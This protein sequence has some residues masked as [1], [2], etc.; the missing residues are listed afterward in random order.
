MRTIANL[1][2]HAAPL[3]LDG[4]MGQEL[5]ARGVKCTEGLWS[6]RAL[7]DDPELVYEVHRDFVAAGADIL[8]TNTYAATRRRLDAIDD[9]AF[10]RVNRTAC[11]LARRAA[12]EADRPVLVAGSLPPIHGSYRPDEVR[13]YDELEPLYREH[14]ALLAEHVDVLLCETMSTADEARA[15]AAGAARTGLPVWVAWTVA[16]DGSGR[17]RSGESLAEAVAALDGLHVE[18][19]LVNCSMPE[20]I[21][22]AMAPLAAAARR[23]FGAYANGFEAIDED[24]KVADGDD[25]PERRADLDPQ[26]YA[27]HA[28]AWARAGAAIVGG[29]CEVGPEHIAAVAAA[30]GTEAPGITRR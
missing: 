3:L 24:T 23:P 22:A 2:D 6:A 5:A 1:S 25:V 17:L 12:D 27:E 28:V 15:A 10:E 4:G 7:L 30:L 18:A 16:D 29:C 13:P 11:E 14:A 19:L 26:R 21:D 9:D 20:S 8:T